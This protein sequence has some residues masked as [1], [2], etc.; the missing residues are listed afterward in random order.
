MRQ[1]SVARGPALK[2]GS[3]PRGPVGVYQSESEWTRRSPPVDVLVLFSHQ[4]LPV[5]S[6]RDH[7]HQGEATLVD[8]VRRRVVL[9]IV[10]V[11]PI[12]ETLAHRA[13]QRVK[14]ICKVRSTCPWDKEGRGPGESSPPPELGHVRYRWTPLSSSQRTLSARIR[15]EHDHPSEV[16]PVSSPGGGLVDGV[17]RHSMPLMGSS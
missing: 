12:N 16:A 9:L 10:P 15:R 17:C 4:T 6:R 5:H 13:Q 11:N 3:G 1:P 2:K 8:K 14:S 7:E